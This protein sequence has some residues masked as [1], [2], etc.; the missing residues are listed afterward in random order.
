MLRTIV[1]LGMASLVVPLHCDAGSFPEDTVM[2][3]N[4]PYVTNAHPRQTF[5]LFRP[6]NSAGKRIPL[7]AWIHGGAWRVG[8]KDWNNVKYLVGHGFAIA[9]IDYRL[10]GDAIFPAQIQDCNAALDFL[11]AHA[12]DYGF[13]SNRVVI[14]GASAGGH[15]ALLLG[16]AREKEFGATDFRAR[17]I[18]DFFGV[19]DFQALADSISDPAMR[20]D[21]MD[22]ATRLLGAD[23]AKQPDLSRK[24]SPATYVRPD[25]PPV[26][27]L[28]GDADP[29]VPISQSQLLRERLLAAGVKTELIVVTGAGHD[30]PAFET[31]DIQEKVLAFLADALR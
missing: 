14:G 23:V 19:T 1:A 26:L 12:D 21:L 5:D 18:L 22:S 6:A 16:L 28:H 27:V 17:C 29:L 4:I 7:I 25:S 9:S 13:D 15:L 8:D 30:G 3:K 20:A 10:S 2:D 31:P 11:L 24:A